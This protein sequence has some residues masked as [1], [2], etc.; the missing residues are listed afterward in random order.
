VALYA[1]TAVMAGIGLR[2]ARSMFWMMLST[3]DY[4]HAGCIA[5]AAMIVLFAIRLRG[6]TG[7]MSDIASGLTMAVFAVT[8]ASMGHAGEGGF[9]SVALAV[10]SVHF[11]GIGIWTGAVFVS[12]YFIL[13][14]ARV[15]SF[16]AGLTDRYLERMSRAA[17]W[18]V[19]AI[20]GTGTYNAWHRVDSVDGLTHSNYGA[21]LLVKIALVVGA[22][23]LGAYN[24]FFGL[25][26]AARSARGFA[27]VRGVLQ[28]ESVLLLGALAA[29]AI[30]GT[31]QAPGAM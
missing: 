31:Q 8:R 19:V 7:R 15:A 21:T 18:A 14:P 27:I 17:L 28:A 1:A 6:G 9:W 11:V 24:K 23:G 22:I 5:I 10:E 29:A 16:A 13:S 4:G 20:V 12:A 30:L 2:E 3:T 26:A 25:P